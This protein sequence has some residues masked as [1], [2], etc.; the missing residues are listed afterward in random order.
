MLLKKC[1][2]TVYFNKRTID[3]RIHNSKAAN[4]I[5]DLNINERITK[6]KNQLK[7]EFFYKA[8]LRYFADIGKINFPLKIDFR[9]KCYL[10]TDM[11]KLFESKKKCSS[12]WSAARC[13][14][15]FYKTALFTV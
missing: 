6:L 2:C 13:T 10:K 11:K 9:I 8:P 15:D 4:N 7:N 3:K 12:N 14:N 5:T 1:T